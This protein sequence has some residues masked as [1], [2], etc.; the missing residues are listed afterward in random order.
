MDL[1]KKLGPLAIASRLRRLTE[2]LYKDGARIY[3]EQ[4]L[5][6]EP[7]WFP[8]F[9]LLKKSGEASVTRAAQALGLTHPAINQIAGEMSKRGLLKSASDEKDKRKRLLRLTQKGK[10]ALSSLEPVWKD[11]E[12]AA[13]ELL[14]EAGG[15]FLA[16]VG[17]LEDALKEKGM[18]V[19]ITRRIKERQLRKVIIVNYQPQLKKNFRS[20]NLEWLKEY[21]EVE[22]EDEEQL[23]SPYEKII[24][25]GGFV[26][27]A[28]LDGKIVGTTALIRHDR[29]TYELTKMAVKR[30]AQGQQVG[31]KLALAAIEKAKNIGARRV[32]LLTNPRLTAACNLYHSLGFVEL[33]GNQPWVTPYHRGGISMSLDLKK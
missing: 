31:R 4:S 1:L 14:S 13:S 11:F 3:Q 29:Y 25:P 21:F 2:W 10:R 15:D 22:K 17:K 18:Y 5:D 19:R 28:R 12:S 33:S 6:F 16:I 7:R 27:F 30:S 23:S 26:L 32:V 20:L 8:L 9:Y 24:K